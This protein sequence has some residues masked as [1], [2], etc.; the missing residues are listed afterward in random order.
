M[1]STTSTS[2]SATSVPASAGTGSV[3]AGPVSPRDASVTGPG[4]RTWPSV[5][6]LVGARA[7]RPSRPIATLTTSYLAGS[8]AAS[9]ERAEASEISCSLERPPARSATRRRPLTVSSRGRRRVG[10][11]RSAAGLAADGQRH[12]RLRRLLR[13]AGGILAEDEVDLGRVGHVLVDDLEAESRRL[14]RLLGG[15]HVGARDVRHGRGLRALG[16]READ[17]RA[18]PG[19]LARARALA[20]HGVRRLVV[21]DVAG[22]DVEAPRLELR[23]RLVDRL[24]HHGRHGHRLRGP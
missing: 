4:P 15:A 24:A 14:E 12:D 10:R 2:P 21:L 23:A 20:D 8:S 18:L 7:Q 3:S 1:G 6:W 9:T 19:R 13:A 16:D 11:R 5:T 17:G 22:A